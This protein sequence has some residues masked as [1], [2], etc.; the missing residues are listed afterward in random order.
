[1][2]RKRIIEVAAA[3]FIVVLVVSFAFYLM[4][5]KVAES[6]WLVPNNFVVFEQ[7]FT[8]DQH[9]ATEYMYWNVTNVSGGVANIHL[10]SHGVN[11]SSDGAVSFPRTDIEVTINITNREVI[12]L[13]D[14]SYYSEMSQGSKWPFWIPNS[15]KVGDA[16]E[17]MYGNSYISSNQ[18]VEAM[19]KS[20]DCWL[21]AYTFGGGNSMNR[22]Y[23]TISGLCLKIQ[24]RME[25]NNVTL[26]IIE[27]AVQSNIDLG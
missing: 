20:R 7:N 5:Q 25:Q 24:T 21:V 6:S 12:T 23:D 27:T 2:A 11:V 1:M 19:G 22:F 13:S 14:L 15:M 3:V 4:E 8:W 16:V 17:T 9:N 10:V 18:T 26:N